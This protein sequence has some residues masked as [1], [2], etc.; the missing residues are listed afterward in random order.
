MSD[1]KDGPADAGV[2][3][4]EIADFRKTHGAVL[5]E[6]GHPEH[7][8]RVG[9]LT[10][11]YERRFAAGG[12][13]GEGGAAQRPAQ[14]N[15]FGEAAASDLS[16][17][18]A[19]P[20][21]GAAYEFRDG[22]IPEEVRVGD[23]RQHAAITLDPAFEG[24]VRGWLHETGASLADGAALHATYL[25]EIN[26][27][28]FTDRRRAALA[29]MSARH[30]S[31]TYGERQTEAL[32]AARRLTREIDAKFPGEDG[33]PGFIEFLETSGL[34]NHPRVIDGMIRAARKRGYFT[35]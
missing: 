29:D 4:G 31:E 3:D 28:G 15:G 16:R 27:H 5:T 35:G 11:L 1:A 34:G 19:P 10:R 12:A 33:R 24:D 32:E 20:E 30:L 18:M 2:L 21:S 6:Q 8:Q 17:W 25:E 9:E 23:G 26:Q 13:A 14:E 7:R 22:P